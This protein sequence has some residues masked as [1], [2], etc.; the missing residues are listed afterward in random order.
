MLRHGR[1]FS[2]G[3]G[4]MDALWCL[5]LAL[6]LPQASGIEVTRA[7]G[8]SVSFH[9]QSLGDKHAAWNFHNRLIVTVEFGNPPRVMFY[10]KSY[11][12]RLAFPENGRVLTISQLRME[13][14]GHYTAMTPSGTT[15]FTL[16]VYRELELPTVTCTVQNCSASIC[17]YTLHCTAARP[18][19]GNVSYSWS[20]GFE[21]STVLV[22]ESPSEESPLTC[23]AQNPVSSRNVTVASLAALCAGNYSNRQAGIVAAA[24]AGAAVLFAVI[25]F[26]IC[27]RS[28]GWKTF[29]L[30][31]TKTTN[32]EAEAEYLTVYAEVGP[33]QQVHLQT[34]T[35]AQQG[36]PKKKLPPETETSKTIYLTVQALAETDN[37]KMGKGLLGSQEQ[38]EKSL[39][40]SVS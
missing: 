29:P 24:V 23:T 20:S 27:W 37:E 2:A 25:F 30:P 7:V 10:N 38:E 3:H 15:E 22:E 18:G 9:I 39:Y 1:P 32:T 16:R 4:S 13:D 31:A 40:S 33:S 26:V 19:S 14:A 5:S 21:G 12:P 8:S 11:E 36:D 34:L 35:D 28:K 6:L 17:Q